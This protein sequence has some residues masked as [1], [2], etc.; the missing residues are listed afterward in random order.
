MGHDFMS[1][2]DEFKHFQLWI[3]LVTDFIMFSASSCDVEHVFSYSRLNVTKLSDMHYQ[4]TQHVLLQCFM[5]GVSSLNLSHQWRSSRYSRT[6]LSG[7]ECRRGMVRHLKIVLWTLMSWMI[8]NWLI[9][10]LHVNM[11]FNI[12]ELFLQYIVP[13]YKVIYGYLQVFMSTHEWWV[14][15]WLTGT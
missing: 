7:W 13:T 1:A 15:L 14:N 5:H 3:D 9:E 11:F 8:L 2:P 10:L 6:R 4:R 12:T